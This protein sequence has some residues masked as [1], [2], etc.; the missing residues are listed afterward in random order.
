[1]LID[2]CSSFTQEV[3]VDRE[4]YDIKGRYRDEVIDQTPIDSDG[5]KRHLIKRETHKVI[6]STFPTMQRFAHII[7]VHIDTIHEWA[8]ATYDEKYHIVKLR[9]K[10]K[11]PR[12]SVA[13]TRAKQMQEA[14]LLENA[15]NGNFNPQ[16]AMFLAK[17]CFGY[18][19]KTEVEQTQVGV[20][21]VV[22]L[23]Q[24]KRDALK[25]VIAA[26]Q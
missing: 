9:G 5:Y 17:N 18:K 4:Y 26:K 16:F 25:N 1:M 2:Y 19:D 22:E 8:N 21:G 20:I 23:S 15:I 24:E 12:F 3:Y 14:I 7:D 11:Y 10:K 6:T 13:F